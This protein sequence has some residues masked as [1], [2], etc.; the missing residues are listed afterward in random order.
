MQQSYLDYWKDRK[1]PCVGLSRIGN[2]RWNTCHADGKS[3][4]TSIIWMLVPSKWVSHNST[5]ICLKH[6][7]K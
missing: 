2:G 4:K 1:A 3:K 6:K 5:G 7:R